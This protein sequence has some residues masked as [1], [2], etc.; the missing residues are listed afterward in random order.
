MTPASACS[1]SGA[2]TVYLVPFVEDVSALVQFDMGAARRLNVDARANSCAVLDQSLA[3]LI[4]RPSSHV[5]MSRRIV[6][7]QGCEFVS[8]NVFDS[9]VRT[10]IETRLRKFG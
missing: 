1:S 2:R 5:H 8:T 6:V 3:G 7:A 10:S 4:A 9:D